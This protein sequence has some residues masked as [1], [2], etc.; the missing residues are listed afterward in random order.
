MQ[1]TANT[2][3]LHHYA[4]GAYR[5][6]SSPVCQY[7]IYLEFTVNS[8]PSTSHIFGCYMPSQC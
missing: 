8:Y 3:H 1:H 7:S 2:H 6:T 4:S 5:L